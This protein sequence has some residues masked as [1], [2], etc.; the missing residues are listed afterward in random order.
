AQ[1]GTASQLGSA[2][3]FTSA[4]LFGVT[5]VD[6]Y[7]LSFSGF[8]KIPSSTSS[9]NTYSFAVGSDDGYRLKIHNGTTT[10]TSQLTTVRTFAYGDGAGA[11]MPVSFP[12]AGGVFPFELTH[13]DGTGASG[14]ELVQRK[15]S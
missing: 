5:A 15:G 10:S 14:I 8:L 1:E 7:A 12:V 11:A 6:N 2:G 4:S 9:D 3:K 13:F